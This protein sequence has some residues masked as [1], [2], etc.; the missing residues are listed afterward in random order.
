M[1]GGVVTAASRP[2][3]P[4]CWAPVH[5]TARSNIAGH[6]DAASE[7]CPGSGHPYSIAIRRWD[8][9]ARTA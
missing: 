8:Q 5:P 2:V 6:F 3:C 7:V 9:G 4:V 1:A